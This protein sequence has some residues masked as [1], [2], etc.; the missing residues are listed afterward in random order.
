MSMDVGITCNTVYIPVSSYFT[1]CQDKMTVHNAV[2]SCQN[3]CGIVLR[4]NLFIG[5]VF[6]DTWET[7]TV[8]RIYSDIMDG[9]SDLPWTVLNSLFQNRLYHLSVTSSPNA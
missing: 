8:C 3:A 1:A 7:F 9:T 5:Q 6:K 4:D 2:I